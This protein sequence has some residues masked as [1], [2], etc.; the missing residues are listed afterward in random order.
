MWGAVTDFADPYRSSP[1]GMRTHPI[2]GTRRMHRGIDLVSDVPWGIDQNNALSPAPGTVTQA[3]WQRGYGN[4]V[5]IDHGNGYSSLHAHL[6]RGSITV[7][8]GD[9]V[10]MSDVVGGVGNTGGSTAPHVHFEIRKDGRAIDPEEF[11]QSYDVGPGRPRVRAPG[12]FAEG[13]INNMEDYVAL[14]RRVPTGP[15]DMTPLVPTTPVPTPRPDRPMDA[16]LNPAPGALDAPV[17]TPNPLRAAPP[18]ADVSPTPNGVPAIMAPDPPAPQDI[19]PPAPAGPAPSLLGPRIEAP[20]PI[21]PA[22]SLLGPRIEAPPRAGPLLDIPGPATPAAPAPVD[23]APSLLGPR[24]ETPAAPSLPASTPAPPTMP[25]QP[26]PLTAS[27]GPA[28]PAPSIP[29]PTTPATSA[30][31]IATPRQTAPAPVT[32]GPIMSVPTTPAPSM[33]FEPVREVA[34]PTPAPAPTTPT[35]SVLAPSLLDVGTPVSPLDNL[36]VDAAYTLNDTPRQVQTTTVTPTAPTPTLTADE[37]VTAA[38]GLFDSPANVQV[39]AA[40]SLFGPENTVQTA[41][42]QPAPVQ[43]SPTTRSQPDLLSPPTTQPAVTPAPI[44]PGPVTAAPVT[45]APPAPTVHQTAPAVQPAAP[46]PTSYASSPSTSRSMPRGHVAHTAEPGFIQGLAPSLI[47]EA[48]ERNMAPAPPGQVIGYTAG[49]LGYVNPNAGA[50]ATGPGLFGMMDAEFGVG[51]GVERSLQTTAA[52]APG[53]I[54][55]MVTGGALGTALGG[56]VGGAVGSL[57][58]G[59]LGGRATRSVLNNQGIAAGTHTPTQASSVATG[60]GG[61][62]F[63]SIFGG[64]FGGPSETSTG[65]TGGTTSTS[66]SGGIGSSSGDYTEQADS[67]YSGESGLW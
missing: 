51:R 42:T 9:T 58:G 41:T 24:T 47:A 40:H 50:A 30:P 59:L 12:T 34:A 11:Y 67:R 56:P 23:P 33:A 65:A 61:G 57:A 25:A 14:R 63:E 54:A 62:L 64:L 17:P 6:D 7:K 16:L 32:P 26:G 49:G 52:A 27:P 21:D 37:R 19:A 44:V 29:G 60:G 31:S 4:T 43:V 48:R 10:S 15:V 45:P 13:P 36:A 46:A 38:H 3:G 20:S 8:P 53:R 39:D 28:A 1:Y 2:H 5:T 22:P 55:G 35:T 66:P 18:P